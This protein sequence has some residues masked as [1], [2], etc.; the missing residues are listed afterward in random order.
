MI[1]DKEAKKY[2]DALDDE[3]GVNQKIQKVEQIKSSPGLILSESAAYES[4]WKI[5]DL[6]SLP[7]K[8][9]LYPEN[10]E[11]LIRSAKLKEIRHWSTMDEHDPIDVYDKINFILKACSKF[12]V[13]ESAETFDYFDFLEID[14]YHILFRIY[15]LTFPNQ[16]NKLFANI[17]CSNKSC[18]HKNKTQ[19]LSINLKGF[20][21]PSE[22]M[23]WY[24][25]TERCFI[26]N[27]EKLGETLKFY[28]PTIG[29]TH[30]IRNKQ[31]SDAILSDEDKQFY[32]QAKYFL[33]DYKK[34]TNEYI[35]AIKVT[36]LTSWSELKFLIIYRITELLEKASHNKVL[37]ICEKC[38]T[39]TTTSVFLDGSFTAKDIFI[40]STGLNELI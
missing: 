13:R 15:E 12:S 26:V 37:S 8:G 7:S 18:N 36:S 16:E 19:V 35:H 30:K 21:Y 1:D 29:T 5:L 2:L 10:T 39:E 4:P 14:R 3:H 20:E 23:Q 33:G 17:K 11:I 6:S 40:I 28:L 25:R 34:L 32:S 38:S 22:L 9:F 27:S 31:K 24:S